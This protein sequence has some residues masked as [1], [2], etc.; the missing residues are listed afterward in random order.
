MRDRSGVCDI[1]SLMEDFPTGG[2]V[3]EGRRL[4]KVRCVA[5]A[6]GDAGAFAREFFRNGAAKPFTGGGNDGY[7]SL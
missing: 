6:N 1:D 7:A 2:F 5:G 3:D 4:C